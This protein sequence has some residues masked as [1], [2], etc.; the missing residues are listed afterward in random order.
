MDSEEV[1]I[2]KLGIKKNTHVIYV[3]SHRY[4]VLAQHAISVSFHTG[5]QVTPAQF[6]KYLI[7]EF[8]SEC[9]ARLVAAINKEII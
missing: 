9:E 7:D 4:S 5:R 3:G 2:A 8:G 6:T 1:D